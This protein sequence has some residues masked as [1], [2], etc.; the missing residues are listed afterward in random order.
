MKKEEKEV[1]PKEKSEPEGQSLALNFLL[2][3]VGVKPRASHMSSKC[4]ITG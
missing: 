2:L 1:S 3:L 4:S